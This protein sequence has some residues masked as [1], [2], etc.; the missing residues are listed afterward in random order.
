MSFKVVRDKNGI[1][2][3]FGPNQDCYEPGA[4]YSVEDSEPVTVPTAADQ[5]ATLDSENTLT[6]RNLR[7]FILLVVEAMK[8]GTPIDL[9]PLPGVVKVYAVEAEAAALRSKL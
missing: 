8:Q 7:E 5:L 4:V 9:S 6:Q 3:A 1:A 2:L